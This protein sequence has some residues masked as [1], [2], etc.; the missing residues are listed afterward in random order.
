MQDFFIFTYVTALQVANLGSTSV[1][2]T[3]S[4]ATSSIIGYTIAPQG[5]GSNIYYPNGLKTNAN[6]AF[7][8]SVGGA[9]SLFLSAQ[10]FISKT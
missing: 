7:T 4:G 5:G 9:A 3:L 8:A 10:G 2:V 6:G 1:L